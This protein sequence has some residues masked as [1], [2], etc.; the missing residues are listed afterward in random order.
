MNQIENSRR[1][2]VWQEMGNGHLGPI[3]SVAIVDRYRVEIGDHYL[4]RAVVKDGNQPRITAITFMIQEVEMDKGW[5]REYVLIAPYDVP[6]DT[7]RKIKGWIDHVDAPI[8]PGTGPAI[9][10]RIA[11]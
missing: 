1:I 11:A 3:G 8:S 6:L 4:K 10:A 2:E 7:L 5:R 9:V